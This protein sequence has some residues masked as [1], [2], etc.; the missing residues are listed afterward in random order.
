[1]LFGLCICL[2]T[3][4]G[5]LC[6]MTSGLQARCP[7]LQQRHT[8]GLWS[9]VTQLVQKIFH[10]PV[11]IQRKKGSKDMMRVTLN[12]NVYATY[13]NKNSWSIYDSSTGRQVNRLTLLDAGVTKTRS[14]DAFE[15]LLHWW[16]AGAPYK[17]GGVKTREG[18]GK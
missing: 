13:D 2:L 6:G 4:P 8:Y 3:A 18:R 12:K 15:V 14:V 17:A 5:W 10:A 7:R 11:L 9:C 16:S 1:M